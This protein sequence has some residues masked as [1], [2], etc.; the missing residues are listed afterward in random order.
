MDANRFDRLSRQLAQRRSR[1]ATLGMLGGAMLGLGLNRTR[2]Q[3]DDEEDG[4]PGDYMCAD[5]A[6][7]K[8]FQE[9]A[10][11]DVDAIPGGPYPQRFCVSGPRCRDLPMC[12]PKFETQDEL[13]AICNGAYPDTCQNACSAC[14]SGGFTCH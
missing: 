1:R 10:W 8:L 11:Q 13:D 14:R 5:I 9:G 6:R 4:N 12:A 3:S 7:C 2:A